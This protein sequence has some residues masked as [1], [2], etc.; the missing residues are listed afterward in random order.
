MIMDILTTVTYLHL[1]KQCSELND[2]VKMLQDKNDTLTVK[3]A[4]LEWSLVKY[5]VD[6]EKI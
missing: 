1:Q 5:T 6:M 4:L 2:E 3:I